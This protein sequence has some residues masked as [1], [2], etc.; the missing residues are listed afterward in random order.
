MSINANDI[1]TAVDLLNKEDPEQ[2]KDGKP[3]L[4]AVQRVMN[5]QTVT[6]ADVA[7]ALAPPA[8]DGGTKASTET[9]VAP[10]VAAKAPM[11]GDAPDP[12]ADKEEHI[13]DDRTAM[14]LA[15]A[16]AL[17]VSK[18]KML[19]ELHALERQRAELDAAI[20]AKSK[21]VAEIDVK[22]EET[23]G[24]ISQADMVKRIQK[25]TQERLMEQ[26]KQAAKVKDA[27][28]ATGMK[29]FASPL[30]AALS[31]GARRSKVILSDGKVFEAPHPRSPE[32][33]KSYANWVH[34]G[35]R[36]PA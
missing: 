25:Q 4:V 30:D 1:R 12:D 5:D 33:V 27:M 19:P 21:A 6:D 31:G 16:E 13:G 32:G 17:R 29:T 22:V 18:D 11:P 34:H 8:G 3:L 7:A 35:A 15:Q 14:L 20:A 9:S 24:Q 10:P 2:W 36:S 26:A 28:G 23:T